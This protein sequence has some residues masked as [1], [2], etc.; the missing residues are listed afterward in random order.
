MKHWQRNSFILGGSF[1]VLAGFFLY[2]KQPA[3][4]EEVD[5]PPSPAVTAE[6]EEEVVETEEEVAERFPYSA[7]QIY[8]F[9]YVGYGQEAESLISGS[10]LPLY[11]LDGEE[12]YLIVP[13]YEDMSLEIHENIMEDFSQQLVYQQE[14]AGAFWVKGNQSDIFPNITVIFT[15]T[16]GRVTEF[17][18]YISLKDG[19]VMANEEGFLF[20][21]AEFE[22]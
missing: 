2:E 8:A 18:P 21:L 3:T 20:S 22:G 6:A 13:R 5:S 4:W 19:E 10:D 17:T 12:Y 16:E 11:A 14:N 1:L 15:T 7:E 9:A